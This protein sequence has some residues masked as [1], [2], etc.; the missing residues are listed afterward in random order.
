MSVEEVG[1]PSESHGQEILPEANGQGTESS[2]PITPMVS[3]IENQSFVKSESESGVSTHGEIVAP[4][5]VVEH[6]R[7]VMQLLRMG[8]AI[9]PRRLT[10]ATSDL[11]EICDSPGAQEVEVAL[12]RELASADRFLDAVPRLLAVAA[13]PQLDEM[14]RRRIVS[15]M[16]NAMILHPTF[17]RLKT[18]VVAT[19]GETELVTCREAMESAQSISGRDLGLEQ[20][21][22][23]SSAQRARLVENCVTAIGLM[24]VL[25]SG[26][27]LD[28]LT[29]AWAETLWITRKRGTFSSSAALAVAKD[30][31][32]LAIMAQVKADAL[33]DKER[34]L[35]DLAAFADYQVVQREGLEAKFLALSEDLSAAD[36]ISTRLREEN[37]ALEARLASESANR[38][39]DQSHHLDDYEGL[40]TRILQKLTSQVD[41]LTNGLH[42]LRD[43]R[44]QTADEFVER[45]A[46]A[47]SQEVDRLKD[48]SGD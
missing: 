32:A 28:E 21:A 33:A 6:P 19:R 14:V 18:S 15:L 40:R 29:T 26:W 4:V 45:V 42:A 11:K 41:M 16:G 10:I 46:R 17:G 12:L 36:Q 25:Q 30:G 34:R 7:T 2:R 20:D 47:L 37:A 27:S 13:Q 5:E 44:I 38:A 24:R 39:A 31:D 1:K 9:G 8:Y 3:E 22:K 23:I 43:G 35:V 48:D